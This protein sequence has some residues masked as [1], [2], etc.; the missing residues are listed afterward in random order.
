MGPNAPGGDSPPDLVQPP[1]DCE[2]EDLAPDCP[3]LLIPHNADDDAYAD[4]VDNCPT[5][6][7]DDQRDVDRDGIGDACDPLVGLRGYHDELVPLGELFNMGDYDEISVI[8]E[9]H[10]LE[11]QREQPWLFE[12]RPIFDPYQSP[13]AEFSEH[14]MAGTVSEERFVADVAALIRGP[15]L[16]GTDARIAEAAIEET[17]DGMTL[18][19]ELDSRTRGPLGITVPRCILRGHG[20]IGNGFQVLADG[21]PVTFTQADSSTATTFRINGTGVSQISIVGADIGPQPP[22][23]LDQALSMT[24]RITSLFTE[25]P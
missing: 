14:F 12:L 21:R 2:M 19:L 4:V 5:V 9:R 3:G 17:R 15:I 23:V 10:R 7:N 22:T 18:H 24:G 6:P 13:L 20:V 25:R 11:Q 1:P 16:S 8:I